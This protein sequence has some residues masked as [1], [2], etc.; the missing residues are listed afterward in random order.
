MQFQGQTYTLNQT[1]EMREDDSN[2]LAPLTDWFRD[3]AVGEYTHY[4][5][6]IVFHTATGFIACYADNTDNYWNV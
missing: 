6:H 2:A 4:Y 3:S 1:R 5:S